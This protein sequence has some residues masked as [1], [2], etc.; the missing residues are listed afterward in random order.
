[1]SKIRMDYVT[2]SSSSSFILGFKDE[3]EIDAIVDQ[4][5]SYWSEDAKDS[6]VYDIKD[7]ITSKEYAEDLNANTYDTWEWRFN[8]K[9]YWNM[10]K[11]ERSSDEY[12]QFIKDKISNL[13]S[14]FVKELDKYNIISIVEY[15]DHSDFGS[16]MEHDIMPYLDNTIR[17]IS[18]H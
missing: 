13:S 10:T 14:G 8:G 7:G 2:N 1:M 4:L 6:V 5:P 18:N 3:T 11:E 17:C 16:V 9:S 15:E 12:K